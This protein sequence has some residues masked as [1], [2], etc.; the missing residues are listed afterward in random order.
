M[1]KILVDGTPLVRSHT[2]VAQ[3]MIN[4]FQQIAALNDDNH[5]YF[6]VMRLKRFVQPPIVG[7]NIHYRYIPLP[8]K[9]YSLLHR[10]LRLPVPVDVLARL[11]PDLAIFPNFVRYPLLHRVPSL[12][13]VH[14]LTYLKFP[15]YCPERNRKFLTKFMPASIARAQA[16]I[17]VSEH[18]KR[19]IIEC[20]KV[21]PARISVIPNAVDRTVMNRPNPQVIAATTKRLGL[22]KNYIL[23]VSTLEPRKNVDGLVKAYQ[24]LPPAL[25]TKHALVLAGGRGWKDDDIQAAIAAAQTAGDNVITLGYAEAADLPALYAGAALF[26]YP[27]FYEGFGI[28]PLEAMACG[29]PVVTADTSS[30]PEVVGDAALTVNPADTPSITHAMQRILSEPKLAQDLAKKGLARAGK[31]S[32]LDSAKRLQ[33]L[34]LSLD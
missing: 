22:P 2:G 20:Y 7:A 29:V 33:E 12:I 5:Y 24:A 6:Y 17:A 26:A 16:I 9:A 30:L 4:L 19:D 28:P 32:W 8:I 34:I 31:F 18:T 3:Y 11:K 1:K 23:F 13:V 15:E 21:D 10:V 25:K 27:S 14:D